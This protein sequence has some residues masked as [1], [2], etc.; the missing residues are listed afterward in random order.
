MGR[1]C[2]RRVPTPP[3]SQLVRQLVNLLFRQEYVGSS[4]YEFCHDVLSFLGD[5]EVEGRPAGVV[6]DVLLRTVVQQQ[7]HQ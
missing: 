1:G 3:V 4:L 2:S 7:S 6:N 5:C